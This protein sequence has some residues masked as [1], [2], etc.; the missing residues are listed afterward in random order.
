MKFWWKNLVAPILVIVVLWLFLMHRVGAEEPK[1]ITFALRVGQHRTY[2]ALLYPKQQHVKW[3]EVCV[4]STSGDDGWRTTSC[5]VPRFAIEEYPLMRN[6]VLIQAAL[7][8]RE[9]DAD[10]VLRTPAVRVLQTGAK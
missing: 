8:I 10:R 2:A 4:F 9:G 7:H 1:A 6:T 5:W 3:I